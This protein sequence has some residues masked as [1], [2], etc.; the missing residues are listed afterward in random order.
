YQTATVESALAH[1]DAA[2]TLYGK[3]GDRSSQA[4]ME[5]R[6]TAALGTLRRRV[7]AI[8]RI[9]E[10]WTAFADL[11]PDDANLLAVGRTYAGILLSTGENERATEMADSVLGGAERLGLPAVA[12]EAL[13]ALGTAAFYGGRLWQA[14][15]LLE[16]ARRIADDA[17]LNDA[18]FRVMSMLPSVIALD[19]PRGALTVEREAIARARRVGYRTGEISIIFNAVEDARRVGDWDWAETELAVVGQLDI[20]ESSLVG[21]LSQQTFF[22]AYHGTLEAATIADLARRIEPLEDRDLSS[23]I[24]DIEAT[25]AHSQGRWAD[26]AHRWLTIRAVSPLNAPYALPKAGRAA[27]LA[28]DAGLA[29]EA[30]DGLAAIGAR[31][32]AMDADRATIRAGLAVLSGDT[33][34][35]RSGYRTAMAGY[36]D[37]GLAWDEALAGLEAAW[38]LGTGDAELAGW[39]DTARATFGRLGAAPM[40]TLLDAAIARGSVGSS[41]DGTGAAPASA[42]AERSAVREA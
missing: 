35:A 1:F 21:N 37:L 38:M 33:G 8:E 36:R 28:G 25:L 11:G 2:S 16:G 26:A 19:D 31:G 13:S 3:L 12:A 42:A 29:Q 10:A 20:D 4:R 41:A 30:L 23:G 17:N 7:E 22:A 39:A 15:T 18:A 14:R 9:S 40:I 34:T 24:A 27:V 32:R 6:A 5:A